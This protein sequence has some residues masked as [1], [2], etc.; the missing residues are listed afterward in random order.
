M[1][2]SLLQGQA[3]VTKVLDRMRILWSDF[4][5][6]AARASILACIPACP[7]LRGS[8]TRIREALS[9]GVVSDLPEVSTYYSQ[10]LIVAVERSWSPIC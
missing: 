8:G 2:P 9:L 3:S 7:V 1:H 10:C 4:I 6:N 5:D